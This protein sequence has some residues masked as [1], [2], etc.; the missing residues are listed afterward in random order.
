M[1]S[2]RFEKDL[3]IERK[4][5]EFSEVFPAHA[6][7]DGE[8][9]FYGLTIEEAD[10]LKEHIP[11]GMITGSADIFKSRQFKFPEELPSGIIIEKHDGVYKAKL[12]AEYAR[13]RISILI[14]LD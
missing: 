4:G 10:T 1:V 13:T 14:A 8:S 5:H 7:R 3:T 12:W 11:E 9:L 2:L 6:T